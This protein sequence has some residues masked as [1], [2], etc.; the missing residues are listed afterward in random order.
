MSDPLFWPL[1]P[2]TSLPR[3]V[4]PAPFLGRQQAPCTSPGGGH[5]PRCCKG[6]ASTRQS[7]QPARAP[8]TRAPRRRERLAGAYALLDAASLAHPSS[9]PVQGVV[10]ARAAAV[11]TKCFEGWVRAGVGWV[12]SRVSQC[13]P[14]AGRVG[15]RV[16]V[17]GAVAAARH[18]RASGSGVTGATARCEVRRSVV[19]QGGHGG[20]VRE[21]SG[22]ERRREDRGRCAGQTR[23]QGC[24][25]AAQLLDARACAGLPPAPAAAAAAW[26]WPLQ[27]PRN[28]RR[29]EAGCSTPRHTL[30]QC[31]AGQRQPSPGHRHARC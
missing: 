26:P 5:Q 14:T 7:C 25:A 31:A 24:A 13:T 11:L 20:E 6:V 10:V 22:G 21:D 9:A 1:P 2:R 16:S 18:A 30:P 27:G 15:C 19:G 8:L 29:E 17:K 3:S 4:P 28:E 12:V 23:H